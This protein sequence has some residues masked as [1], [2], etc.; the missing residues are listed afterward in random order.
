MATEPAPMGAAGEGVAIAT[1]YHPFRSSLL[2][3]LLPWV[4]FF[5]VTPDSLVRS[6]S[7]ADLAIDALAELRELASDKG[8]VA[9]GVGLSIASHDGWHGQYLDHLERLLDV[10]PLRWHSEH[11]GYTRVRGE[12]LGTMLPAPRIPQM[13]ELLSER[14]LNL[15][16]QFGLPFLLENVVGLLPDYPGMFSDA[17]FLNLLVETTGCGLLIDV[18]NLQCDAANRGLDIESFLGE[19]RLDAVVELHVAGGIDYR[20]FALDVHSRLPRDHTLALAARVASNCPNLRLVTYELLDE[21]VDY[22]SPDAVV[23]SLQQL[24]STV[25]DED[26]M[27]QRKGGRLVQDGVSYAAAG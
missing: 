25:S 11:L 27:V 1:S 15:E 23:E 13:L 8:I 24:R 17:E 7:R 20:G 10:V 6:P 5:E 16:Q 4:D 21:A 19:L 2:E 3:H 26:P 22:L 14:V 12:F 9:H 18:Y